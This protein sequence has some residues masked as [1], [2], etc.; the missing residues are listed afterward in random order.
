[1]VDLK[2]KIDEVKKYEELNKVIQ[3]KTTLIESLKKNQSAPTRLIDDISKLI[4]GEAWL[5]A[6][7]FNN[8]QVVLEGVS[9][10]NN[11]VVTFIDSLKRSPNFTDV[12]LEETKQGNIENLEVYHFKL[13]FKVRS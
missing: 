11:E 3:Q 10:S 9:F 1:M 2:K 12:F 7:T 8:P 4:P 6:V 13:N 5:T